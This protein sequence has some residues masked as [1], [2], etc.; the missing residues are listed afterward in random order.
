MK[1][2]RQFNK[3]VSSLNTS[4]LRGTLFAM[5]AFVVL[6]SNALLF[7]QV[8]GPHLLYDAT[9][10]PGMIGQAAALRAPDVAGYYQPVEIRAPQGVH[11]SFIQGGQADLATPVPTKAG[12]LIGQVYRFRLSHIPLRAGAELYPTIE[13]VDRLHPPAGQESRFP[14]VVELTEEDLRLATTGMLVTRVV[15]LED[16]Q[17]AVPVRG[18]I[19]GQSWFEVEPGRDP[20]QV[21]DAM[22]RPMAIIRLGAR[23]PSRNGGMID[24]SFSFGEP[25]FVRYQPEIFL[26]E[27]LTDPVNQG[28]IPALPV[29]HSTTFH[30][31]NKPPSAPIPRSALPPST[32][33]PAGARAAQVLGRSE[34]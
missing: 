27:P 29:G 6:G 30:S 24:P 3:E 28:M 2:M 11:V 4:R 8:A 13:L 15:Y 9:T 26:N 5:L 23:T 14:I 25:P 12:L 32:W 19:G 16:P 33:G 34:M 7:A 22:G 21:A 10:P 31:A 18:D 20:I 17:A 1:D